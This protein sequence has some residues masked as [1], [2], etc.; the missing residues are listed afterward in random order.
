[1]VVVEVA[2]TRGLIVEKVHAAR[3]AGN[4]NVCS[5]MARRTAAERS[6]IAQ[7]GS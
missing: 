4:G 1:M 3:G 2:V 5:A 7:T 6:S